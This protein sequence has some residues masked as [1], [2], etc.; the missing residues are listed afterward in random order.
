MNASEK[1]D[2]LLAEYAQREQMSGS[3]LISKDG[4]EIFRRNFGYANREKQIPV[5]DTTLFRFYSL[6]KPF[7]AISI[8]Q[9]YEKGLVRLEDRVCNVLPMA[10]SLSPKVTL[11]HL[12]QHTSGLVEVSSVE[13]LAKNSEVCFE[14]V[15]QWLSEQP[16]DYEPGCDMSYRNTNYILLSLIVEE[17]SR[18]CLED[19]LQKNVFDP[20]GMS[21]ALCEWNGMQIPD[22]ATGYDMI[23]GQIVPAGYVNMNLIY[24]AGCIVGGVDDVACLYRAIREKKLLKE[25]TWQLIFTKAEVGIFGLGCSVGVDSNY[26]TYQHNGGHL[27]FR[28]IHRYLPE[29]DFDIILL[30]NSTYGNIRGDICEMVYDCFLTDEKYITI[31]MDKGFAT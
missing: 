21:T 9:L 3:L 1:F 11:R 8:M 19:Y 28:T 27:G 29:I 22:L 20:L 13:T 26:L 31:E 6:S 18:L 5:Q 23:D 30:S 17:L 15:I 4:R 2:K 14:E 12:L 10:R 16:L 25:S 7:V 24:G